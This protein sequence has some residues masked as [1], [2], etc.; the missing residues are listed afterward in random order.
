MSNE[1]LSQRM[2]EHQPATA[3]LDGRVIA[4]TGAGSGI[5][6]AVALATAAH[7]AE[8]ILIGRTLAKLEGVHAEIE[9]QG[10]RALI[11][12]L[13]LESALAKDFDQL[14]AAVQQRY[15]HL[16][17]LLHN[18][19]QLGTLAPIEHYDVP[20]WCRVVHVNLTA[21]FA[22][23]QVLL[24][25]LR[26]SADASLVH[27]SS[28]V[29]RHGQAFWGAY[30][31]TKFAIEGLTQVLADELASHENM[32]VNAIN[33][34]RTRTA[35]RRAAYPSEDLETLV[36]PETLV[37]SYLW[38]LGPASRGVSGRSLDCQLPYWPATPD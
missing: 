10:G 27:T 31:A 34:G 22:L 25:M 28:A 15:G 2:R 32:R 24:P 20:T 21:A 35:L 12:P 13:N 11:A 18:A 1:I 36:A 14:A 5:G 37:N 16:D 6:R 4:I 3:E 23:T 30:A 29:G 26:A 8:V 17:G 33:P 38:L 19:A 7:G 9:T